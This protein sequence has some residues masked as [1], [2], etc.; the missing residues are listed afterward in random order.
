MLAMSGMTSYPMDS[1]R[2]SRTTLDHY[3]G[4]SELSLFQSLISPRFL[5]LW[6]C[7]RH[8]SLEHVPGSE[9]ALVFGAGTVQW[10][11]GLDAT[12][13]L[14]G[15]SADVNMQQATVNLLA[16][17]GVQPATLQGGLVPAVAFQR[18]PLHPHQRSRRLRREAQ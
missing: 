3:L 17:M 7:H 12:H 6:E 13:D 10:S 9:W 5:L 2:R 15:T 16:D 18:I 14:S 4:S 11:W 1:G 8:A